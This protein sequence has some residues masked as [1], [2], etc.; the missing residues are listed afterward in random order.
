MNWDWNTGIGKPFHTTRTLELTEIDTL[1]GIFSANLN[2]NV[3]DSLNKGIDI[4]QLEGAL[5]QGY[6]CLTMEEFRKDNFEENL[7][8]KPGKVQANGS[9]YYNVPGLIDI[10]QRLNHLVKSHR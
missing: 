5:M 10:P 9:G 6:I 3:G 1:T 2:F 7:W 8:I 4:G